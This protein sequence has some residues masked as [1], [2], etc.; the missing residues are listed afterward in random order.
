MQAWRAVTDLKQVSKVVYIYEVRVLGEAIKSGHQQR[1]PLLS[2]G[3][4]QLVPCTDRQVSDH[5]P[6]KKNADDGDVDNTNPNRKNSTK[7]TDDGDHTA[8]NATVNRRQAL[9][10]DPP[11]CW[12]AMD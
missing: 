1:E 10:K 3:W 12:T 9:R 6:E 4:C 7:G 5:N 2:T 11:H 8:D